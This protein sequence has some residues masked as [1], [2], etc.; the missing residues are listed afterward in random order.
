MK[1][2]HKVSPLVA[3]VMMAAALVA[4]ARQAVSSHAHDRHE[5]SLLRSELSPLAALQNQGPFPERENGNGQW[6]SGG[7]AVAHHAGGIEIT[8][9]SVTSR[10]PDGRFYRLGINGWEP[11]IGVDKKGRI[12]YQARTPELEPHVMRSTNEGHTWEIVSPMIGGVPAQPISVDPV[13]HLDKDTGRVFTN[14]IPPT[15][16]CQPVSYTDDAG[17]SWTNTGICGHFDHQNIFSGPPPEGGDQPRGY[18]NVVY[19]CAINLVMLSGTSTATTCGRSLDGG[20]TWLPTGE[21]AY[22]TPIG[23]DGEDPWCDG[24]VG[25]GFVG[26]DGTV[27]LPRVWCGQ[28]FLSISKDEGLTWDQ[29][30]VA[31]NGG[32]GHEA[33]IAADDKGNLYF[34]WVAADELPYLAISRDGGATWEKPLMIGPPGLKQSSL[35][36]IDVGGDG[37]I[38]ITYIGSTTPGKKPDKWRWNGY[39]TMT[40]DALAN[41]PVFYTGSINAPSDPLHIGECGAIRCHSL[42]DFFDVTI[43]PDGTPWA[44]YVDACYKRGYCVPTFENVGVRGEA[45][46]GRL[47]GGPR[48]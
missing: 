9:P 1:V 38:A 13:L 6:H 24:A 34:T 35:A 32:E 44:A 12:F 28:P 18:P 3:V 7:A 27:Y 22:I 26:D 39:I 20:L 25:H 15:L 33:G 29:V 48:L 41:R 17:E 21:P 2:I 36:A 5:H 16:T 46:V 11:T 40:A 8:D 4:P 47:V 19:Y 31:S 14:N 10:A 43:G 23:Q 37:K 30:Q 45:V 42:G